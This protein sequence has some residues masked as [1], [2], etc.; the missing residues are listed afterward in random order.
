MAKKLAHRAELQAASCRA[1]H[2][3]SNASEKAFSVEFWWKL[4]TR[5]SSTRHFQILFF[6][7]FSLL[8]FIARGKHPCCMPGEG[9]RQ[10]EKVQEQSA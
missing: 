4:A 1:S 10:D 9:S 2:K 5:E 3:F 6:P 8:F 7:L